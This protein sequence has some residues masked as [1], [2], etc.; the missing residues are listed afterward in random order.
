MFCENCGSQN[1]DNMLNCQNCGAP[2]QNEEPAPEVAPSEV[3]TEVAP[4]AMPKSLKLNEWVT[5]AKSL[6]R[7]V[8]LAILSGAL[9][10]ILILLIFVGGS[11]KSA[12]NSYFRALQR[13][14][15]KK[16][17]NL[18]IP[19][20]VQDEY[21]ENIEDSL[22]L[23]KD[24]YLDK[25][26]DS[27]EDSMDEVEDF[28]W[29]IKRAENLNKLDR[30]EDDMENMDISDLDDFRD[31]MEDRYEDY[32]KFDADRISEAYAVKIKVKA[33][34]DGD[35]DSTTMIDIVYRYKGSWYLLR[36]FSF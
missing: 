10:L 9:A 14:D 19:R 1:E 5:Y 36:G 21:F 7:K 15:A 34:V 23:D 25:L 8:V 4:V 3:P 24:D 18:T 6:P 11:Y 16:M 28:E 32:D 12:V 26:A 22:D 27:L 2:L 35:K 30:L 17:I 13:A 33:E 31:Y 20:D 29:E